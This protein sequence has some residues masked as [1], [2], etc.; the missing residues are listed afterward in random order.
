M[1]A[2]QLARDAR[3]KAGTELTIFLELAGDRFHKFGAVL[4]RERTGAILNDA[5]FI[6]GKIERYGA[7]SGHFA[8]V[9]RFASA[10]A[11]AAS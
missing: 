10:S 8:G 3:D 2:L 1:L 9:W 11:I 6:V 4:R 7:C 5:Q